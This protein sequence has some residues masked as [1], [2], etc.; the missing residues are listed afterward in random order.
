MTWADD[1]RS[2]VEVRATVPAGGLEAVEAALTGAGASA[3]TVA[4]GDGR[5]NFDPGA[6]WGSNVV[7]GLFEAGAM[8]PDLENRVSRAAGE[9]LR[10]ERV[11]V[12]SQD[13]AH[14]WKAHF[15]AFGVGNRLWV[16]PSWEETG[17][18]EG[19]VELRL[20]PGM[21]FGT[22]QHETTRLCLA[23]LDQ[24]INSAEAP[25]VLDYGCGSGLLAIAAARLGAERVIAVDNDPQALAA[26]RANAE[27]NGV[28]DR[29]HVAGIDDEP[30]WGD[31]KRA[32]LP[33]QG[34]SRNAE[35]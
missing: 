8:P 28:A 1:A 22:G 6:V 16:R 24:E 21:A 23:W 4:E 15:G 13:W 34:L 30:D 11:P 17:G 2:W 9:D 3:V 35:C 20:D 18:P 12:V 31:E 25:T 27:A 26:T 33:G 14:A 29:I 7:T 32:S 19:R 10:V 5:P